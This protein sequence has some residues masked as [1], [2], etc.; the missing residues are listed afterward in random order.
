MTITGALIL[1]SVTW[2]L[3]FLCILPMRQ[4]SQAEAGQI[5]PGSASSA[6]VDPQIGRKARLTTL[7][8]VVLW[9]LMCG[10]IMSG[11]ISIRDTDVFNLLQRV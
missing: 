8:T 9:L 11:W 3:V 6:P 4:I 5:V 10:V 7:I 1:F 2:F